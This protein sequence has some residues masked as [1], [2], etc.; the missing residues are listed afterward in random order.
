MFLSSLQGSIFYH[1][2]EESTW[3]VGKI[4]LPGMTVVSAALSS[5]APSSFSGDTSDELMMS[6][7]PPGIKKDFFFFFF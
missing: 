7:R 4:S 1:R 5:Y 6:T 3:A 2:Q